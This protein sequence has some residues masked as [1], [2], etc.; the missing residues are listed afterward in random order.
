VPAVAVLVLLAVAAG[1]LASPGSASAAT[2]CVGAVPHCNGT[3]YA[4]TAVGLQQALND[5]SNN[6]GLDTVQVA[7]GTYTAAS[8]DL[9]ATPANVLIVVGSGPSTVLSAKTTTASADGV[10]VSCNGSDCASVSKLSIQVASGSAAQPEALALYNSRVDHIAVTNGFGT[11]VRL[12]QST[13]EDSTVSVASLDT[14]VL[15]SGD[16]A[17][18]GTTVTAT[19]VASNLGTG[20]ELFVDDPTVNLTVDRDRII[21]FGVGI[22]YEN[23]TSQPAYVQV[24]NSL[25]DLGSLTGGS[26]VNVDRHTGTSALAMYL[27]MDQSTIHGTASSGQIG[28]RR[29][30][31]RASERFDVYAVATL[32]DVGGADLYCGDSHSSSSAAS[33]SFSLFDPTSVVSNGNCGTIGEDGDIHVTPIYR[34]AAHGDLRPRYN[35]PVV[36]AAP[37]LDPIAG[38]LDLAGAARLVNGTGAHGAARPDIGAYEYQRI[39]PH[40]V[41]HAPAHVRHGA[42][43]RLTAAVSDAEGE[44][45]TETWTVA[46]HTYHGTAVTVAFP[47]RGRVT[48]RLVVRDAAGA[49]TTRT[50][51]VRVL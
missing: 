48:V 16:D 49:S 39:P 33:I 40:V 7:P 10:T 12:D 25:I 51:Q 11:G 50:A 24:A 30:V 26:G 34:D 32:F 2:R 17:L 4:A 29:V 31:D 23:L 1:M 20:V 15:A 45:M 47:R 44:A 14:G 5:S 43:A 22:D 46:G 36:D 3:A 27:T 13:M 18:A 37:A 38:T 42:R 8:W 35:S 19:G 28:I 21:G 41:L 6:P 9:Q